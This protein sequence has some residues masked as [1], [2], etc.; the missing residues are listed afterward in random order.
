MNYNFQSSNVNSNPNDQCQTDNKV[1]K[2]IGFF[3]FVEL[4]EFVGFYGLFGFI[5]IIWHLTFN[6][7]LDFDISN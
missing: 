3:E 5:G 2:F 1:G 4:L 6:C 7:H